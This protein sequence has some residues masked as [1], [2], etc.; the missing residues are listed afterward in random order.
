MTE[1]TVMN[2]A[3]TCK[4]CANISICI[5]AHILMHY[6]HIYLYFLFLIEFCSG[7][8]SAPGFSADTSKPKFIL[9]DFQHTHTNWR[10]QQQADGSTLN[11]L[12][13]TGLV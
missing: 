1:L 5:L 9:M 4:M 7:G 6:M 11:R 8:F 12:Q 2:S 3:V 13:N 10:I